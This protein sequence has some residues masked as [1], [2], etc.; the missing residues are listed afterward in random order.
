MFLPEPQRRGEIQ[1]IFA[2]SLP[3]HR[4]LAI[5][6]GLLAAGFLLQALVPYG[7][8]LVAG[9]AFLLAAT[10]LAVV[11]GFSNAPDEVTGAEEWRG[12]TLEQLQR[13]LTIARKSRHWD[14]SALDITCATGGTVF[15]AVLAVSSLLV[16]LLWNNHQERLAIAVGLDVGV[17]VL[18]H[19][20]TGVRRIL[21][22]DP[23][24]V[25]INLFVSLIDLWEPDRRED[26][27]IHPQMQVRRCRGGEIPCDAKL[28]LRFAGLGEAFLGLQVQVV[29][30]RVEGS[31][32]PY[33]YCVL[34][35]RPSLGMLDRVERAPIK[36]IVTEA[37]RK[38]ADNVDVL[39]VR[40]KTTKTSGY[41]TGAAACRD[42]FLFALGLCR[43]LGVRSQ[44]LGVRRGRSAVD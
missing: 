11:A 2:K 24:T 35:A 7:F 40:Q 15:V 31:D 13:V 5:V 27:T 21:T 8:A 14:Q 19:W 12:A 3:Y 22:N 37:D 43:Q 20:M 25:K 39:V 16:L 42:I 28:V 38:E 6:L 29:L 44:E 9:A 10:L 34:V 32:Y 33:L 30:N 23:L 41:H 1:F 17:L 18:P 26:E 4:R 36:S